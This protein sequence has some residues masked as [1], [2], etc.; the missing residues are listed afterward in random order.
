MKKQSGFTL[1]ELMI[2]VAI[3]AILAAIA[4]P[5]YN[6]YVAEARATKVNAAFEQ[7][8]DAAQAMMAR[9]TA[10]RERDPARPN[11]TVAQTYGGFDPEDANSWLPIFNPDNELAPGANSL[12]F[13]IAG[14]GDDEEGEI[15]VTVPGSTLA[16]PS[17][18]I[19]R[20]AFDSDGD[21]TPDVPVSTAV[22]DFRGN[23]T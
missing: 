22:I 4:I 17:V 18:T 13:V 11:F 5:A 14:S 7:A 8:V 9:M 15:V 23:R 10:Q 6:Q 19:Q 2:V 20:L 3:I 16:Q 1:I 12:Q 21:N